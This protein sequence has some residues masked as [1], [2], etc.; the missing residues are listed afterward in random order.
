MEN[1]LIP[2]SN[3]VVAEQLKKAMMKN[4]DIMEAICAQ[5]QGFIDVFIRKGNVSKVLY[6]K[7]QFDSMKVNFDEM[8][9]DFQ[10]EADSE[11]KVPTQI[12]RR[13]VYLLTTVIL[14]SPAMDH[15]HLRL[16]FEF[17]QNEDDQWQEKF[18]VNFIAE[19][20]FRNGEVIREY[21]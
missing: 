16:A 12:Y 18:N 21:E 17:S 14:Y 6:P 5:E 13:F 7:F 4:T 20:P 9:D 2:T 1:T 8:D 10:L 15:G 11:F 19:K 3:E